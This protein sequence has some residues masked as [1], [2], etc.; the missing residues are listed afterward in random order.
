M[1]MEKIAQLTLE[2]FE[3]L[4]KARNPLKAMLKKIGLE[5]KAQYALGDTAVTI[6]NSELYGIYCYEWKGK[7]LYYLVVSV[8]GPELAFAWSLYPVEVQ[9]D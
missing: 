1:N 8:L 4:K 2:Q 6:T 3:K 5:S 7:V 9:H